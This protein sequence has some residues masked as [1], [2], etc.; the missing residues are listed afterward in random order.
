MKYRIAVFFKAWIP[1]NAYNIGIEN[2]NE[3]IISTL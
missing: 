1:R 2:M 3:L